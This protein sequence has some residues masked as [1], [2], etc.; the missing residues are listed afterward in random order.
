V[1][2]AGDERDP[3]A[4]PGQVRPEISTDAAG[5]HDHDPHG[6]PH[7]LHDA[8]TVGDR[9]RRAKGA[10][11]AHGRVNLRDSTSESEIGLPNRNSNDIFSFS[12][13]CILRC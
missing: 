6:D 10:V 9:S 5:T 11:T 7:P 2:A 8:G 4:C 3:V 1:R 12:M 13:T